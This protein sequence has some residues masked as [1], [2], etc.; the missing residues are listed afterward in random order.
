MTVTTPTA[1]DGLQHCFLEQLKPLSTQ[2]RGHNLRE[3]MTLAENQDWH[4]TASH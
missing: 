3:G 2:L 1:L 4:R